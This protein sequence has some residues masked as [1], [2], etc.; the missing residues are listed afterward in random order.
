MAGNVLEW[1]SDLYEDG[2]YRR[3][4]TGNLRPPRPPPYGGRRVTRG[5]C[6]AD[7]DMRRLRC[8]A[9]GSDIQS[10]CCIFNGFRCARRL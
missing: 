6:S 3:Y 1:C 4:A 7:G 5:G 9:R 8:A 10:M 2:V